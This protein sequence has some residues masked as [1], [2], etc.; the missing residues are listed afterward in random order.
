MIFLQVD[1]TAVILLSDD[2]LTALGNRIKLRDFCEK[3]KHKKTN[4][5]DREEKLEKLCKLI[6]ASS[7]SR[8]RKG[9]TPLQ[10]DAAI[11]KKPRIKENLRFEFGWKHWADGRFKQKKMQ[12]GGGNRTLDVPRHASL[13]DCLKMAKGLFFPN[14]KSP[15]GDES[16]MSFSMGNYSGEILGDLEEDGE[17]RE[18]RAD[19]Y[20]RVTGLNRPRVYLLSKSLY[21]YDDDTSEEELQKPTFHSSDSPTHQ[22][23]SPTYG[24]HANESSGEVFTPYS[25]NQSASSLIGS[26]DERKKIFEDLKDQVAKSEATDREKD[27]K[28]RRE[29]ERALLKAGDAIRQATE[30]AEELEELRM[31]RELRVPQEPG[32]EEEHAIICVRHTVLGPVKRRFKKNSTMNVV[33]DWVDSLPTSPAGGI[34]P[35]ENVEPFSETVL[36]MPEQDNPLPLSV[37]DPEVSFYE[38]QYNLQQLEDTIVESTALAE[39]NNDLFSISVEPPSVLLAGEELLLDQ[40]D[41]DPSSLGS[42]RELDAKRKEE[43]EKLTEKFY[44]TISRHEVC[45]ELLRLYENDDVISK[46]IVPTFE[47]EEASGDG[48]LRELYSLFW[49]DFIRENCDGSSQF[50]LKLLSQ[51]AVEKYKIIGRIITHQFLQCGS[52]PVQLSRASVHQMLF[53]VVEEDCLLESFL[54]LLPPRQREVFSGALKGK[55]PFP[56]SLVIDVLDDYKV[57]TLPTPKNLRDIV[58]KISTMEFVEKPFLPLLKIREGMGSFWNS[59]S[60]DMID[61]VYALCNP[62]ASIVA[63]HLHCVLASAQE[64]KVFRWLNCY[65]SEAHPSTLTRFVQFCTGS[66]MVIPDQNIKE[67]MEAMSSIAMRP[68][69]RACFRVLEIP[70]NYLSFNQMKD[71][72]DFFFNRPALWEMED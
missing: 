2:Q 18:F 28:K 56:Q 52:F 71:N 46:I 21:D 40:V 63:K 68:K 33:Y 57:Q 22:P 44:I 66:Q 29:Q 61:A 59:V 31:R 35:D 23:A 55:Q 53:E 5:V 34:Y 7:H 58:L 37:S 32:E 15:E 10:S 11:A 1:E 38:G 72:L 26:S 30:E 36:A 19:I 67:R 14:G 50:A 4:E 54:H 49:N 69:A 24:S 70:I 6:G 25:L 51:M 48:V 13:H 39:D 12:Q 17:V 41:D 62:W 27:L 3:N 43:N 9:K 20:K 47:G 42:F 64:E 16:A 65:L 45:E 60:K 8:S